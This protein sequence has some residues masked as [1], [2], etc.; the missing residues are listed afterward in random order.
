MKILSLGAGVQSTTVFLMSLWGVLPKLDHAIF[1][2]T[3]WEPRAVYDHLEL[4]E[5]IS[6]GHIPIHRVG[7]PTLRSDA[8]TSQVRGKASDG[9]RWASIPMFTKSQDGSVGMIKRQCTTEYKIEPI[10]KAVRSIL[11]IKRFPKNYEPIEQ[12][13]GISADEASRMRTSRE[14]WKRNIYPLCNVPTDYLPYPYKRIDCLKWLESRRFGTVPRSACLGCPFHSDA[15]WR[16]IKTRPDEWADVVEFDRTIRNCGGMR[17][18]MFL[19]RSC[20]PLDEIDFTP[21]KPSLWDEE[22]AGV[23]GV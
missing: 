7:V 1:A 11:G 2:D 23:C 20:K 3:G 16:E 12:W 22:C 10:E 9:N 6:N 17:G 14:R 15:E 4:L 8:L 18:Q 5:L 19:H 13:F 21:N